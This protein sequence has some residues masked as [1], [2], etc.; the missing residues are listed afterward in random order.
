MQVMIIEDNPVFL[1]SLSAMLLQHFPFLNIVSASNPEEADAL[2]AVNL[3][4]LVF[5]DVRLGNQ[6]GLD[7]ISK[8]KTRNAATAVIVLTSFNLPE[9]RTKAL[10]DGADYFFTKDVSACDI[11]ECISRDFFCQSMHQPSPPPEVSV[12]ELEPPQDLR[13]GSSY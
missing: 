9:Y 13:R 6:S 10:A 8:I 1:R 3:P 11:V 5:L 7:L 2:L 4:E 12:Q